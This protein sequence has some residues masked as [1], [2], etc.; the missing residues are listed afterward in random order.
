M[1]PSLAPDIAKEQIAAKG[2]RLL[3]LALLVTALAFVGTL[4]FEFLYDDQPQI[5]SN[6]TLSSWKVLP[7]LFVSHSWKFLLPGWAGNYYRPVFMSWLLINRMLFD[8]NP[9]AWHATTVLLHVLAT[10]MA[11]LVARQ[12]LNNGVS[13]AFVALLFG[14]HPIHIESVAWVSGVTDPLMALFVFAAFWAWVR[15]VREPQRRWLWQALAA[16]FYAAGCLSKETALFLPIAVVVYDVLFARDQRTW[17]GV[18]SS[19]WRVWP[20]WVVAAAY[21]S[22]RAIVLRGL[23]H[24]DDIPL[25]HDLLTVPTI[26]WGY[27][28]RLVWP[29]HLAVFYETPPVTS[30][31]Q[32]RFW[33]PMLALVLAGVVGWRIARRSRIAAFSFVWMIVFLLPAII[34]LPAF[35]LGEWIHDRYL[36][37]PAFGFC[38]LLVHAVAQLPSEREIFGLPATPA[39]TVFII[40]IAMA[41]GT[42]W[43]QQYW[44]NGYALFQHGE[45]LQPNHALNKMHLA[46]E[47][48]RKGNLQGAEQLYVESL[49]LEPTNWKN[50]FAYGLLLFYAGKY[51]EADHQ[52]D[53]AI[54]ISGTDAN[55]YFYQGLSRFNLGNYSGAQQAFEQALQHEPNRVRYHFWRGFALERQ[56][57]VEEAR[58][59]Y[60]MELKEH[61]ETD[62]LAA[63][64]LSGL[65]SP[66][67]K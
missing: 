33:L 40:A 26:F 8:V 63:Q 25:S 31:L 43:Q 67:S 37:L 52:F 11:F 15:G 32:W 16:F 27:M 56:N 19:T 55:P 44:A 12:I 39:A 34:G 21:V 38:L 42:S 14:L 50:N 46:N 22:V 1:K 30:V 60:E 2:N 62:T 53:K 6:S 5:V 9:L 3:A 65:P 28:R 54:A 58:R 18:M 36:Y 51:Q 47:V 57:R 4:R 48:F 45:I 13:A 64:R 20:F 10:A 23:V 61:P 7:S 66:P 24:P 35:P 41:L 29:V 49:R 17:T 59:E